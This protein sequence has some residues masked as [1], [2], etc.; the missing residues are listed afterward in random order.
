[1]LME[2]EQLYTI[3]EHG[4]L[5]L[6]N[7]GQGYVG[8]GFGSLDWGKYTDENGITRRGYI[9]GLD[10]WAAEDLSS[11]EPSSQWVGD[12]HVGQ[13]IFF[14]GYKIRVLAI[15]NQGRLFRASYWI[16]LATSPEETP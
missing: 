7:I 15:Q 14:G 6:D 5:H 13:E 3:Q 11:D 9:A 16:S 8:I 12:V 4:A 10:M 2:N 1:M